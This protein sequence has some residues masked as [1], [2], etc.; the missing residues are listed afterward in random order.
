MG[1]RAVI[2]TSHGL[3]GACS[4]AMVLQKHPKAAVTITSARRVAGTLAEIADLEFLPRFIAVC[5]LGLPDPIDHLLSVLRY[6]KSHKVLVHWYC[7]RGYLSSR[8][9]TLRAVCKTIFFDCASNTEAIYR[10]LKIASNSL[11][12]QLLQLAEQY[13]QNKKKISEND[14]FWHDLVGGSSDRYFKYGD[15]NSFIRAIHI[16]AGLTSLTDADR[17]LAEFHRQNG[18]FI[19]LGDSP[20]MIKLRAMIQRL[21][22]VEEPV[23]IFGPSGVG[24]EIAARTLHEASRRSQGP[25]VPVNCAVLSVNPDL[26]NDRLFGHVAGA[27]TG[28]KEKQEGAF[29]AAE[30]GSLFLDELAELPLQAQTQLLRALEEGAITP[31]GTI[32]PHPVDVRIIAATNQDLTKSIAENKFRL[33]LYYRLNVLQMRIPSLKERPEDMK[34]IARS[35]IYNLKQNGYSLRLKE[36]DW[37]AAYEYDWPGNIR[38]FVN[39]LKRSAYF[40]CPLRELIEQEKLHSLHEGTKEDR[41]MQDEFRRFLPQRESDIVPEAEIRRLYMTRALKL[42]DGNWTQAARRLGVS[43]NT[44]RKWAAL[45]ED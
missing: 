37:R 29:D 6:L 35:A 2:V 25:F 45:N 10:S 34:P 11:A 1:E 21:G 15:G 19:P 32:Q 33:D 5:G 16:L 12:D 30:G 18:R 42:C 24:K 27:F 4:A 39:L 14:R 44:L 17:K 28:A 36:E 38:Q 41:P 13:A 20:A 8:Q 23:L 40:D 9:T 26:A 3:D 7:G 43:I 31:L 22:P